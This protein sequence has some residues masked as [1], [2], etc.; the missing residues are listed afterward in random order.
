MGQVVLHLGS[1][2]KSGVQPAFLEC[3][4]K[5][6][7]GVLV[8]LSPRLHGS[9]ENV[10]GGHLPDA[11]VDLTGGVV[12]SIDLHSTTSNL[13]MMVKIAAKAG[14]LMACCTPEGVSRTTIPLN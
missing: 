4:T 13:L 2:Q 11:L 12:T 3:L 5:G 1:M 6:T 10:H 7:T 9:Y 8:W 14:S